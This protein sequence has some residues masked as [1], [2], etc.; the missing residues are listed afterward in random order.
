MRMLALG[1]TWIDAGG[2]VLALPGIAPV[3]LRER[4]RSEGIAVEPAYDESESLPL[5]DRLRSNRNAVVAVDLPERALDDLDGFDEDSRRRTL[6][7]DDLAQLKS[8]PVALVLN[9]NAHAVRAA[10]PPDRPPDYLLGPV[11]ALLRREFRSRWQPRHVPTVA[12][13]LLITFGGADPAGMTLRAVKI[14]DRLPSPTRRSLEVRVLLGVV[15]PHASAIE[16]AV[17]KSSIAVTLERSVTKMAEQIAWADLVLVSGGTTV[18]ELAAMGCP[19]LVVQTAP[20][21]LSEGLRQARLFDML[22]PAASLDDA[23]LADAIARRISD[24]AW[25]RL[26]ADLGPRIVDGH[27]ADRVVA[28]L[29]SLPAVGVERRLGGSAS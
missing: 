29:A 13:R 28:A 4:L 19:A 25:R 16:A 17:T 11:Y 15:N 24:A 3:T 6:L 27:G 7:V 22:G 8:Y 26:M 23:A 14:L 5:T 21:E 20:S 1:Q 2:T 9:Q 18:L 10:Y 12:K